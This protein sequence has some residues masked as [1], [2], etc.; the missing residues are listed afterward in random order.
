MNHPYT[1]GLLATQTGAEDG[2]S[3]ISIVYRI[4]KKLIEYLDHYLFFLIAL[5][6]VK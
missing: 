6:I 1:P 2:A 4:K 5:G 3:R